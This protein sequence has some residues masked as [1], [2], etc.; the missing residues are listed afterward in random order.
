MFIPKLRK[1]QGSRSH[2]ALDYGFVALQL[3]APAMFG[4]KGPAKA[5][6]LGMGTAQ[7]A[8]N[9]LTDQPYGLKRV[10]SFK[11]HGQLEIPFL[12]AFFVLPMVTGAIAQRN[13]RRFFFSFG[14]VALLSYLSTD[15]R[16]QERPTPRTKVPLTPR[17]VLPIG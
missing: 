12:P 1:L 13:A 3:A 10:I 15:Y 9:V 6:A 16:A 11:R 2:G 5:I 4:L 17:N 7:L 14:V 8:I